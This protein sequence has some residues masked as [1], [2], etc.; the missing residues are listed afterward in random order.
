MADERKFEEHISLCLILVAFSALCSYYLDISI[1]IFG[2]IATSLAAILAIVFSISILGIQIVINKYNPTVLDFFKQ[3]KLT[4]ITL[5]GF[6]LTIILSILIAALNVG[7]LPNI[8]YLFFIGFSLFLVCLYLFYQFYEFMLNIINPLK[9]GLLLKKKIIAF[10][11]LNEQQEE[12]IKVAFSIGD[13]SVKLLGQNESST[14]LIY[15]NYI[16][17]IIEEV[18]IKASEEKNSNN[19]LRVLINNLLNQYLKIFNEAINIEDSEII[20]SISGK[21]FYSTF[22]RKT[23]FYE[24]NNFEIFPIASSIVQK[25]IDNKVPSR[26]RLIN[27]LIYLPNVLYYNLK[28]IDI[29]FFKLYQ[30]LVFDITRKIIDCN[31]FSLFEYEIDNFSLNNVDSLNLVQNNLSASLS[32]YN[33]S[34]DTQNILYSN[35]EFAKFIEKS[36]GLESQIKYLVP[37]NFAYILEF[38]KQLEEYK[39]FILNCFNSKNIDEV[40]TAFD[41]VKNNLYSYIYNL[42]VHK[43]FFQIGSHILYSQDKHEKNYL[44]YIHEL[45][46]HTKPENVPEN[47]ITCNE[48]PITFN[49]F[50]LTQLYLYGGEYSVAWNESFFRYDNYNSVSNYITRYYILCI[51]RCIE[52]NQKIEIPDQEELNQL[53]KDKNDLLLEFWYRFFIDLGNNFKDIF[54]Q[55]D[56][57][58]S[59]SYDSG[60]LFKSPIE[61]LIERTK[62]FFEELEK[63]SDITIDILEGLLPIDNRKIESFIADIKSGYNRINTLNNYFE[64]VPYD[65]YEHS[66]FDFIQIVIR[67]LIPKKWFINIS[68]RSVVGMTHIGGSIA[69]GEIK[70]LIET[71]L[72]DK[73]I[74]EEKIQKSSDQI[75]ASIKQAVNNL[76]K[77]KYN[78]DVIYIHNDLIKSLSKDYFDSFLKI[79]IVNESITL[80]IIKTPK[81]SPFIDQIIVLDSNAIKWIYKPD[82]HGEKLSVDIKEYEGKKSEFDLIVR[83][84]V[85]CTIVDSDM[86]KIINTSLDKE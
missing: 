20:E 70:F 51:S 23:V 47:V 63:D 57:L 7:E 4:Q 84:F 8:K 82:E 56:V 67:R 28:K 35:D 59:S 12:C 16:D 30:K 1:N 48:T 15:L 76:L 46:Y 73:K 5:F 54:S 17:D 18:A 71:I 81:D 49:P 32:L 53:F 33:L 62:E 19:N 55:I 36:K 2:C 21:L 83:T 66:K 26:Y 42:Y 27:D 37:K 52:L 61:E 11:N 64:I 34:Q 77:N 3:S 65:E 45:W 80:K 75:F 10:T 44:I 22:N 31:D 13:I 29:R 86:I 78:P 74:D 38:E 60:I 41:S 69:W 40:N 58:I 25:A 85:N 24:I 39:N 6:L 68:D 14:A 50:W 79:L 72:N 9:L 43:L